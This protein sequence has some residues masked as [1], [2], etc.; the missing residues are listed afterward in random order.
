MTSLADRTIEADRRTYE[1]TA[2][3]VR[4]LSDDDLVRPSGA[5]AWTVAQVVSHLGSGAEIHVDSLRSAL[6]G[7]QRPADANRTVWARWDAIS[8]REQ[9]DGFLESGAALAAAYA[10]L[11]GGQRDTLRIDMGFLPEPATLER[12]PGCA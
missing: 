12:S 2:A 6:A 1:R 10:E 4:G 8:P 11:D 7:E 5:L 9:A 3:L